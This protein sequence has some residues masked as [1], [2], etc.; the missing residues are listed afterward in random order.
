MKN[1]KIIFIFMMLVV[2]SGLI[3]ADF[4]IS[5]GPAYTNYFVQAKNESQFAGFPGALQETLKILKTIKIMQQ[6]LLWILDQAF[7]I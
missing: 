6:V 2:C 3:F 7:F 5:F 4:A 1:K